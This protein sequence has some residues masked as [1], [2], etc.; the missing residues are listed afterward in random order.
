MMMMMMALC[1][2]QWLPKDTA[3]EGVDFVFVFTHGLG[4]NKQWLINYF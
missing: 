1:P 3:A 4:Q 2:G